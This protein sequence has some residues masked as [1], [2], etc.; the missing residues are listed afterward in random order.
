MLHRRPTSETDMPRPRQTC[1]IRNLHACGDPSE[2]NMPAKSNRNFNLRLGISVSD[3][4]CRYPMDCR[5][6]ILV[7]DG[8]NGFQM[9]L[10]R[11]M[12]RSPMGLRSGLSFSAGSPI[13]LRWV[14]D[15]SPIII[16]FREL[17]LQYI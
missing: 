1:P 14:S 13:G 10:R 6:R 4:A 9:G 5:S 15:R 7:S 2:T 11:R 16:H 8:A 17:S 3:Q 12:L